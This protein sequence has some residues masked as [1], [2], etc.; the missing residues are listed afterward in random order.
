MEW[1]K[2]M[3]RSRSAPLIAGVAAVLPFLPALR[4][5]FLLEWDDGGFVALNPGIGWTAENLWRNLTSN[6]QSVYTPLTTL[7]L[8]VEHVLWGEWAAGYHLVNLLLYGGCAGFFFAILRRFRVREVPALLLTLLWAW[9]PAKCE[10]VAWIA[11]CKGVGSALFAFAAFYCFMGACERGRSGPA[12]PLLT[13]LALLFKPWVLPLCGVMVLY[14]WC[15]NVRDPRRAV[16]VV[17][18]SFAAGVLGAV[19]VSSMTFGELARSA[20]PAVGEY[21][22]NLWR[23]FGA[24]LYPVVLNPIHPAFCWSTVLP[25]LIPGVILAGCLWGFCRNSRIPTRIPVCFALAWLGMVLPVL[26]SGSFTNADYADRYNFLLS[27]VVWCGIGVAGRRI[28][29]RRRRGCL[30]AAAVLAAFYLLSCGFY[31]E[32]FSDTRILFARAAAVENPPPK[33]MEGLGVVAVNR[34]DPALLETAGMLFLEHAA[35]A[36]ERR[37]EL[38][39]NTGALFVHLAAVME[40]RPGSGR[41]MAAFLSEREEK[42]FYSADHFLPEACSRAAGLLLMEGDRETALKLLDEQCSIPDTNRYRHHFAAGLA[43]FLRGERRTARAEWLEALKARPGDE[44]LLKNLETLEGGN[45][46]L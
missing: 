22:G 9:N 6:L 21:I 42:R 19:V 13:F 18:P 20:T 3:C 38:F 32:T 25:E 34:E 30:T 37:E 44:R 40:R 46:S 36:G 1:V 7:L 33:A 24:A 15:R 29:R 28:F 39:L 31:L 5:G 45:G 23:Y 17:W 8:M 4:F 16:R 10:T 14:A 12:A 2:R 35:G 26:S 11:E 43:A 41:E 27:A